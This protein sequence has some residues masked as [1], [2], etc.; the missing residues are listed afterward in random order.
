MK[1]FLLFFAALFL[2]PFH[3]FAFPTSLY[4]TVCITD[5][6][7]TGWGNLQVANYFTAFNEP[8][9]RGQSFFPDVGFTMGLFTIKDWKAEV[10]VD[11]IGGSDYP[12]LFNGKIGID[13]NKLS[14]RAPSFS[15]GIYYVGTKPGVT[16]FNIVDAVIG[17]T[18]PKS[19]GGGRIFFG[20]YIGNHVVG[21]QQGGYMIG[22][23]NQFCKAKDCKG[24][25]YWKVWLVADYAS[26]KN[27]VGG[28]G[29]GISYF[30]NPYITILMGP[31]WFNYA[32][33]NGHWKWTVQVD[34]LF[35]VFTPKKCK[36]S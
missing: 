31:T 2:L 14:A 9:G 24:N 15:L 18:I 17:K 19:F 35:K 25:D 23:L 10:G 28:G 12:W 4:W 7:P 29:F 1:K 8:V 5:V 6:M 3:I 16:N 20:A 34:F 22:Y 36:K 21:P 13:E 33:I 11:Y 27:I 30:F 26:G 32:E